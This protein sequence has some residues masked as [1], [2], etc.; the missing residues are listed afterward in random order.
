MNYVFHL[1]I[2]FGV[3]A[4]LAMG[5]NLVVG[6]CGLL[7]LAH[8][9]YFAVGAYAYALGTLAWGMDSISALLLAFAAGGV[10][11]LLTSLPTWRLKGD[12][13]VMAS[14]AVQVLIYSAAYNWVNSEAPLGSLSNL[15]NGPFGIAGV[16]RP[17]IFGCKLS[18]LGAM[19]AYS[20]IVAAVCMGVCHLLQTAPWGRTLKCMRDDELATKNLGK[21]VQLLKVQSLSVACALA[22]VAGA[23]YAS[24]TSYIDPSLASMDQ[25][26]LLL[27]MI[28]VG[29]MG[30]LRGPLAGAAILLLIPEV[31]R[32][33]NIPDAVAAEIRVMLYGLM[34][35]L[36]VRFKPEGVAGD[37]KVN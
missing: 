32:F 11:S 10:L 23:I 2:Y 3:Y 1:L 30:N 8:A 17:V 9:G 34:L 31:L 5:L 27:S 13:F 33:M 14:M 36:I 18:S 16:S 26:I 37:Y 35:V 7:T 19:A 22:A 28:F 24:Y 20:L 21:N 4:I 25:S 15:T 6:Y 29:G 12:Y